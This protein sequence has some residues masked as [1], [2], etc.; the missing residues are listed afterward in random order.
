MITLPRLYK[1]DSKGKTRTILI[2]ANDDNFTT[3]YGLLDGKMQ[4]QSTK[5]ECK[6]TGKANETSLSQQAEI[7]ARALWAKKCK[8]NYS[9]NITAP[10]LVNLPM[11]ISTFDKHGKK[12]NYPVMYS[13]KLNGVN[14]LY[15]LENNQLILTSRGGEIYPPIPHLEN[16]VKHTMDVLGTN[17]L[18]GELYIHGKHLQ[19]ITGCVKKPKPL[20][21]QLTFNVFDIP[22]WNI[23][24]TYEERYKHMSLYLHHSNNMVHIIES[25]IA[26]NTTD[27][28]TA[29]SEAVNLD[30]EGIVIH[31]KDSKY[32][33]NTRSTT[34]MKLKPVYDAEFKIKSYKLDKLGHTVFN[35][36]SD[37]GEFNVK[38]KGTN[39]ERLKVAKV[40]DTYIGKWLTIEY[41]MLSKDGKPL[42]PVG[43]NIR[44]CT[45]N[46][47]PIE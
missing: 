24:A 6:N 31:N 44:S 35:C 30:Y 23:E 45:D 43:I 46:G 14:A 19:D 39:A 42:K 21:K 3:E 2:T 47:S 10:T 15:T 32:T 13:I 9:T 37:G 20:S 22:E 11:K 40:A 26:L 27:L 7:E 36:I 34:D 16:E 17:V 25:N 41:E 29:M 4:T 33:Y 5:V 38:M 12:L 1:T 8:A 28:N 18:A